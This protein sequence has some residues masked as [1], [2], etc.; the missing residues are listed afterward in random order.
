MN[1]AEGDEITDH[2]AERIT[3]A[4]CH[5]RSVDHMNDESLMTPPDLLH[6]RSEVDLMCSQCHEQIHENPDAVEAFR[7]KWG[8]EKRENGRN[9]TEESVCTDCHGRHTIPRR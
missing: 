1:F 4:H 3:C 8:G 7:R 9:V 2:L 6:G 5:G